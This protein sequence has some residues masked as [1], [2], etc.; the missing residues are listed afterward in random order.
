[1]RLIGVRSLAIVLVLASTAAADPEVA[2]HGKAG[3][4][5]VT[6]WVGNQPNTGM[7]DFTFE[8]ARGGEQLLI[9]I[10]TQ[11]E[12]GQHNFVVGTSTGKRS[13]DDEIH[14]D[15]ALYLKSAESFRAH[16]LLRQAELRRNVQAQID[17]KTLSTCGADEHQAIPLRF[18]R[19][20]NGTEGAFE[21]CV[22]HRMSAADEAAML[23]AVRAEMARREKLIKAN[24]KAWYAAI[25]PLAAP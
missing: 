2:R 7:F 6:V 15:L 8:V 25:K 4:W 11:F 14:A 12:W 19:F 21:D 9:G 13:W 3:D 24:Y 22:G 10:E 16:A 1:M 17:G 20:P 5:D 18:E 23:A